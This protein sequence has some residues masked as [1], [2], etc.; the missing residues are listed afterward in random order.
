M[1]LGGQL[2]RNMPD[3]NAPYQ[4]PVMRSRHLSMTLWMKKTWTISKKA[5]WVTRKRR[6]DAVAGIRYRV[7][8]DETRNEKNG[9]DEDKDV[10][11]LNF[12]DT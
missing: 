10:A 5:N 3:V 9:S 12:M 11:N 8:G 7:T 6:E 2:T 4:H 1:S